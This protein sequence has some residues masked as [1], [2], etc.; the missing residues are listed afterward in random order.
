MKNLLCERAS[1]DGFTTEP[2]Q[3]FEGELTPIFTKL[4]PKTKKEATLGN[5]F[6]KVDITLI[7]KLEKD[8]MKKWNYRPI[9]LMMIGAFFQ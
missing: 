4:S 7:L 8:A 5:S 9:S 3:S 2:Y 6:Y 1:L